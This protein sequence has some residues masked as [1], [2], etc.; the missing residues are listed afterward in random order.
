MPV[1]CPPTVRAGVMPAGAG[2]VRLTS[3]RP[4]P[5][6]V[7]AP[8][9][10]VSG[11]PSPGTQ[12]VRRAAPHTCVLRAAPFCMCR[13]VYRRHRHRARAR[14]KAATRPRVGAQASGDTLSEQRVHPLGYV[15]SINARGGRPVSFLHLAVHTA[16]VPRARLRCV[17][18]S[19]HGPLS[20]LCN[21]AI[22]MPRWSTQGPNANWQLCSTCAARAAVMAR[23]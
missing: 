11:P 12:P 23:P 7:N 13:R 22:A 20:T 2:R 4:C 10:A 19:P 15:Y 17:V 21:V 9:A 3:A 6:S 18:D 1:I 14:A 8:Q 16:A 5:R